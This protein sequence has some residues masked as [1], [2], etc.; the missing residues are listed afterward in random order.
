MNDLVEEPT[1]GY[2]FVPDKSQHGDVLDAGVYEGTNGLSI[3][4]VDFIVDELLF[5]VSKG[6]KGWTT[7]RTEAAELSDEQK[8]SQIN[9]IKGIVHQQKQAEEAEG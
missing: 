6:K 5:A 9:H 7:L 2:R 4:W 1:N 3:C 8:Q